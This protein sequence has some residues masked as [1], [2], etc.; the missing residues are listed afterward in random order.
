MSFR[1]A[2]LMAAICLLLAAWGL[3][4]LRE[5]E[6][7]VWVR[8]SGDPGPARILKFYAS[9][10]TVQPG[11]KATLCYGVENAKSVRISPWMA[12]VT[13]SPKRCLDVFPDHTTHYTILAEGYD[14]GVVTRSLT[15]PVEAEP[16]PPP[17]VLHFAFSRREM[18]YNLGFQ[19]VED[20]WQAQPARPKT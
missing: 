19:P 15:L 18:H 9:A 8:S 11:E 10:G 2:K 3:T 12:G 4:L 5:S 16:E 1:L 13:P 14:G 20:L 6:T 7:P 17:P